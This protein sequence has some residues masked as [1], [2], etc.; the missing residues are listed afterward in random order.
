MEATAVS[1]LNDTI[2]GTFS[3]FEG[4][5]WR[6]TGGTGKYAGAEAIWTSPF[7]RPWN[8]EYQ[9]AP[10]RPVGEY[11][12]VLADLNVVNANS[13]GADVMAVPPVASG[14]IWLRP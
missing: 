11:P 2:F 8:Y 1:G 10:A 3:G 4:T 7:V 9:E 13:C 6:V 5:L 12:E 14:T